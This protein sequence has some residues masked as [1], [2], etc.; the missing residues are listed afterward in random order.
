MILYLHGFASCGD[1]NKTK[2]LK[3]FFGDDEV[4]A[5]DL[6]VNPTEAIS[7]ARKL[8]IDKDIDLIIGS[9]LGGFYANYLSE[10]MGVK[11]VLINP[12]TQP[13][14]TLAPFIGTNHY[15]CSGEAFEF[16]KVDLNA[17]FEISTAKPSNPGQYLVLLQTGDELLDY[18]KAQ[19]KYEG[20]KLIVEEGGNHRFENLDNYLEIIKGFREDAADNNL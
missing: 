15:W 16:T 11:A 3:Q 8:I 2:L 14:I 9:S 10:T 20:A 6:P 17:L 5:P 13:F 18:V 12:S 1:S 4:L 19:D 7:L